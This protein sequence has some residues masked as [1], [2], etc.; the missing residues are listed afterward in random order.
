MRRENILENEVWIKTISKAKKGNKKA[1]EKII[2]MYGN[3]L[4]GYIINV[5]HDLTSADDIYQDV[6]I[7]VLRNLKSYDVMRP[8]S[9]WLITIARNTIY[10]NKAKEKVIEFS[11]LIQSENGPEEELL[12]K[13]RLTLLNN[14]IDTLSEYDKTI[15]L[16]KYFE[17]LSNE[18]IA[19]RLNSNSRTIKWQLYEA[20]K[21]LKKKTS[22]EEDLLWI[23]K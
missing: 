2:G 3:N 11:K 17:E 15:I 10:D 5:T 23:A 8:F 20:K 1:Q 21:R 19:I 18:E 22:G 4:L 9:P 16:L 7:K 6:W 14:L 13:E 12:E